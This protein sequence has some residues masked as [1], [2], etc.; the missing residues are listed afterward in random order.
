MPKSIEEVWE[1]AKDLAER[2]ANLRTMQSRLDEMTRLEY[3]L[4]PPLDNFDWVRAVIVT[5]PYDAISAGVRALSG[6]DERITIDPVTVMKAAKG[7]E[8]A[9]HIANLWE[10]SLK[11]QMDLAAR[12]KG[13]LREESVRSALQYDEV[14]V[15]IVHL[16][17]QIRAIEKLGGNASRQRA[18]MT[19]GQFAVL[20]RNP[21]TVHTVWSDYMLEGVMYVRVVDPK[22][23]VRFWGDRASKLNGLVEA[24]K[25][26][27]SY[28]LY[29]YIDYGTRCVYAV[30]GEG[31]EWAG[32]YATQKKELIDI[33]NEPYE[34]NFLPWSCVIGGTQLESS[35][36]DQ[37]FPLL[38]PV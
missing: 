3:R 18:A 7:E 16:A 19:N 4:P 31:E 12:R 28:V 36:E 27:D 35:P 37:R 21:Q 23:I 6:L 13:I 9:K 33:L 1:I 10:V 14:C 15:Q 20:V 17:T 2:D 5:A 8:E 11:W 32:G 24:G 38:Y 22:D 34:K 25:A 26:A 30:P 29:D